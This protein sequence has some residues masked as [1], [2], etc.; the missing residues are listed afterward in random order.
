M[1]MY[2]MHT[3]ILPA[4]DDGAKNLNQSIE[5]LN[6]LK[7]QGV[8]NVCLTPHFYTN[9]ISVK[10]FL[11][12]RSQALETLLPNLPKG[13]RVV[14]GAEVYVCKYLFNGDDF[15]DVCFGNSKY[16]MT[17]FSYNSS[18]NDSSSEYIIRLVENYGLKPILPHVERYTALM[19]DPYIIRE[20]K[21]IG[22]VIQTNAVS[23]S[24]KSSFFRRRKLI[25][26]IKNGLI[27]VLGTDAHSFTHN[28]PKAYSEA[29]QFITEKAGESCINKM[30]KNAEEI[31][32]EAYL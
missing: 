15:S 13:M 26:L 3:H 4:I 22:V 8:N 14:A 20:L 32:N 24:E 30:M 29:V 27:D 1:Q 18:F 2:D 17:E 12:N 6:V 11:A 21:D 16:I 19:N 23:Y 28:P 5:L 7:A 25:K 31:F 10:D 9:E